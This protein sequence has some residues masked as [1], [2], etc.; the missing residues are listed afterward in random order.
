ML[1]VVRTAGFAVMS[2]CALGAIVAVPAQRAAGAAISETL[3][4]AL[5][6]IPA[7]QPDI[8]IARD[9]P[10]QVE[11]QASVVPRPPIVESSASL[12][13]LVARHESPTTANR[14]LD[15]LAHAV[16]FEAKSE[17]LNGQLA[18]AE[19]ILNRAKSGRFASTLCGVVKQPSQF[20]FVRN[21][22]FPTVSNPGMWRKAVAIAHIAAEGLW[23][24]PAKGAM[25]FHAARVAPGW[26]KQ[27]IATIG[28]H[29][30]YR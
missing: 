4:D 23:S 15:C 8:G 19:V 17:P 12:V 20:S 16:Y 5:P 30:F 24:G 2:F 27:R 13:D 28:N 10:A 14:D 29:I 11:D 3:T 21:G 1:N 22:A 26:G 6:P 18:V 9:L 7:V 25:Y